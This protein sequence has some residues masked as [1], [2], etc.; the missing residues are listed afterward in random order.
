MMSEQAASGVRNR[1]L[2]RRLIVKVAGFVALAMTII[3]L[4][5]VYVMGR[6][7]SHQAQRMLQ[8]EARSSQIQLENRIAYLLEA[9]R[10]LA[11]NPFMIN[12]LIDARARSEDLPR[13]VENFAV[14]TSLNALALLDYDGRA[15]FKAQQWQPTFNSSPELRAAL[16]LGH[17]ALYTKRSTGQLFVIA[18][19]SYYSTSQGALVVGFDLARLV[20]GA[21][22]P[23]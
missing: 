19:I 12:G 4:A 8:E 15:V 5:V 13:L 22:D 10:R 11:E 16:S 23:Q 17:A 20:P 6:E 21:R 14:G 7:L 2:K 18:P 3:T 9:S 1:S